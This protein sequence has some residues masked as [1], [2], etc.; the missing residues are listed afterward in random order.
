MQV[1]TFLPQSTGWG[2]FTVFGLHFPS[3]FLH[4]LAAR[5]SELKWASRQCMKENGFAIVNSWKWG[6]TYDK[7]I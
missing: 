2:C 7:Q 4:A 3:Q 1:Y 6:F 5:K